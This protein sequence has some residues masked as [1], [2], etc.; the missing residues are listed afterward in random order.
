MKRTA[1]PDNGPLT[2]SDLKRMKRTPRAKIIRRALKL[3]QEE[4]A[5]R[6]QISIGTLRDWEQ[7]RSEPDKAAQAYLKVIA[8]EPEMVRKALKAN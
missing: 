2:D 3:S 5:A 1:D 8:C 7:N 4:F 6:Y